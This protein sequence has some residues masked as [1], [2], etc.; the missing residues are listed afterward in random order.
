MIEFLSKQL[1]WIDVNY[2]FYLIN[3]LS[4]LYII[5]PFFVLELIRYAWQKR[6]NKNLVFDSIANIITFGAFLLI[7]IIL[8][9]LAITKLYY[10]LYNNA[11]LP[12]LELNWATIISCIV[13]ADFAYYWEH[14]MMHRIGIGWATH[15]VHHSSPHFN[16]SVAYRFGPLDAIMPILFSLPLVMLGYDPILVLLSEVFVQVFQT[17]LHTEIIGKLTKPVEF[18]FNTPSHHR[19][20]HGSNRQYWDKNYAGIL[21]IWDRMLG[22]FEPEVETVKYGISEP[23][24]STNPIKVFF[25]GI[26]RL[27][28]KI[29]SVEGF[30]NKLL[31]LI[32][33]PDWMPKN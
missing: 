20:H 25:H 10:W 28:K 1:S 24:N 16:M 2:W 7:E 29:A 18:I 3:D 31:V 12:H 19:V 4:L 5:I 9:V 11:S 21:I 26:T 13:L 23:L 8:G 15:T 14:R 33:P 32:K 22:T 27:F 17:L 30:K 6:L